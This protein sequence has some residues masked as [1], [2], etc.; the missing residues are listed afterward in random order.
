MKTRKKLMSVREVNFWYWMVRNIIPKKLIYFCFMH[1]FAEV[2][3]G[4]GSNIVVPE[5]TAIDAI[6]LYG[7]KHG[8]Q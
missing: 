4:E 1:V 5:L 7:N 8:I 3:T 6:N 2:T